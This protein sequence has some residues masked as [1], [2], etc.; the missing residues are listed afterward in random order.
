MSLRSDK[1]E[2]IYSQLVC[3]SI[4]FSLPE[5][6]QLKSP[7]SKTIGK[8]TTDKIMFTQDISKDIEYV[9]VKAVNDKT[10]EVVYYHPVEIVTFWGQLHRSSETTVALAFFLLLVFALGCLM[11][12]RRYKKHE[13]KPLGEMN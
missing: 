8:G 5:M 6:Q 7:E 11:V 9:G 2:N 12:Y 10:G 4:M 13:Y 1:I 3:P